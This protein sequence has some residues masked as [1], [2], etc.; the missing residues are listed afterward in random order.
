MFARE[1]FRLA[2]WTALLFAP[3]IASAAPKAK[4]PPAE[5]SIE[6]GRKVALT[7][8]EIAFVEPEPKKG[9]KPRPP[10]KPVLKLEEPL[11][12]GEIKIV[13]LIGAKGCAYLARWTFA[14]AGDEGQIDLCGDP[15]I[16]LTD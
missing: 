6:N 3:A 4:Q 1:V 2:A 11:A 7:A 5:I 10:R 13:K 9:A 14:D 8:F 16:V 15:K 12:P